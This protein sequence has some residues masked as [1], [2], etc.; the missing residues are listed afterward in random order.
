MLYEVITDIS[1]YPH[2][3][4]ILVYPS[5]TMSKYNKTI[6]GKN[7]IVITYPIVSK[8]KTV[9]GYISSL[10]DPSVLVSPE[11][12][13]VLEESGYSLMVEQPE[14]TIL[15]ESEENQVG[16]STWGDPEFNASPSLLQTAVV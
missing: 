6:E 11:K 10:F 8:Q 13:A 4:S 7:A 3:A 15:S 5:P 14:G 12:M 1:A 16:R 9:T 2:I